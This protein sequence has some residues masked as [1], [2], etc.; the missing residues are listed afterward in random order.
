MIEK[1]ES[2]WNVSKQ[3]LEIDNPNL[4]QL[5]ESNSI[6]SKYFLDCCSDGV[7]LVERPTE[8]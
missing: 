6:H 3:T 2:W 5:S 4:T 8:E 1:R 7:K